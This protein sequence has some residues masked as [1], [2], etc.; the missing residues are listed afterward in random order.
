MRGENDL[1]RTAGDSRCSY[2]VGITK[3]THRRFLAIL[4]TQRG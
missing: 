4:N 1:T 3:V 2:T